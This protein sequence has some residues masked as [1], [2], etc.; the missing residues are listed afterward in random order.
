M[1]N[2]N[3]EGEIWSYQ[4]INPDGCLNREDRER[5]IYD[6]MKVFKEKLK[7]FET[8]GENYEGVLRNEGRDELRGNVITRTIDGTIETNGGKKDLSILVLRDFDPS[9]N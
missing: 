5:L 8:K 6:S 7:R 4:F 3:Y 2:V 1:F 9:L